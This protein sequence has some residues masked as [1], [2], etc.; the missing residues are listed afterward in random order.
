[1]YTKQIWQSTHAP[2]KDT[3]CKQLCVRWEVLDF[4]FEQKEKSRPQDLEPYGDKVHQRN[5]MVDLASHQ[6]C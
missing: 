1:M 2:G 6:W 5:V 4:H 3:P